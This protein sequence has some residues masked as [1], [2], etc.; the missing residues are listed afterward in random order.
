MDCLLGE[1]G[2]V[3]ATGKAADID[4]IS[5]TCNVTCD[6]ASFTL[7]GAGEVLDGETTLD[8]HRGWEKVNPSANETEFDTGPGIDDR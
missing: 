2:V 6:P 5:R 7:F 8:I 1:D 4:G 3:L